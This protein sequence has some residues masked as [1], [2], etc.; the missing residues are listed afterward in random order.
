M[1]DRGGTTQE[2]HRQ[3]ARIHW[4]E[5]EAH[6]ARGVVIRVAADL[7]LVEVAACF[8]GDDRV[9]VEKWLVSGQIGHLATGVAGEWSRTDP[10]L[11]AVVVAP[12]VLVQESAVESRP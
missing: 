9:A 12:W 3:T 8:A 7:D 5:L 1:T 11:W 4:P 10:E 2:L 6:F